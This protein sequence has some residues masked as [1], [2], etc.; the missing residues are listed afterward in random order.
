MARRS[1]VIA[2]PTKFWIIQMTLMEKEIS[3]IGH[4]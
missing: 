4:I 2:T 1:G 3:T